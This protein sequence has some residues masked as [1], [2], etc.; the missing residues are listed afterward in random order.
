MLSW[1][2]LR[3][4]E[5]KEIHNYRRYSL[6]TKTRTICELDFVDTEEI[7]QKIVCGR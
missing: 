6:N 5:N 2:L 3:N 1:N 7:A 4:I